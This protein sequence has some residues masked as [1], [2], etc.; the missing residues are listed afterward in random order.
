M[1]TVVFD[2]ETIPVSFDTL[3]E[4]QKSY[5]LKFAENGED[6]E[7]IKQQ[8]ALWA[9]TN[10][11]VAIG[12]LS[13]ESGKGAVYFQSSAETVDPYEKEG[14]KYEC[15]TEKEILEKFW[16]AISFSHKFVTFNGR[17]FDCPV[18]MLR[19]AMLGV[20]PTKNL[21]PY[22]YSTD[23]HVDLLEQ[24]T[25]YNAYRKFNLDFYCKAFGIKS[26]K[27]NGVNGHE[28]LPMFQAGKCK[29]IAEYCAGDLHATKELY[30]RWRDSL[31]F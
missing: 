30:I 9:P 10:R 27:S 13:V 17:G 28:V 15:G 26:P 11:I 20:K 31:S 5:L 12:M 8:M 21:A 2:I 14:I 19:S 29:E 16:K 6:E 3:D 1:N 24:L 18:L 7:K 25:F 23:A 22:R 4:D